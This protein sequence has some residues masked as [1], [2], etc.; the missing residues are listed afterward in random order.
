MVFNA[1]IRI[2]FLNMDIL[3]SSMGACFVRICMHLLTKDRERRCIS[4][5]SHIWH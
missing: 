1:L 4:R 2:D 5:R 3:V